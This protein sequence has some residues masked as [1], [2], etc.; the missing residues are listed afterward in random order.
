MRERSLTVDL[1]PEVETSCMPDLAKF[2]SLKTD[3]NEV[4]ERTTLWFAVG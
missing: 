4:S 1:D 3:K 2:C